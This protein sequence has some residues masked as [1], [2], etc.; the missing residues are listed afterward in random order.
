M[1][2]MLTCPF[3]SG[4]PCCFWPICWDSAELWLLF[5]APKATLVLQLPQLQPVQIPPFWNGSFQLNSFVLLP[6]EACFLHQS[7]QGAFGMTVAQK[8]PP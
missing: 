1:G 6:S 4:I 2:F 7:F 8:T 5:P 3:P